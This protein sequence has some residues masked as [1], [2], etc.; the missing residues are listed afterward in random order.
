MPTNIFKTMPDCCFLVLT[1]CS[2]T[3]KLQLGIKN[4]TPIYIQSFHPKTKVLSAHSLFSA[5]WMQGIAIERENTV[6]LTTAYARIREKGAIQIIQQ[7][8]HMSWFFFWELQALSG[9]STHLS[10]TCEFIHSGFMC[11]TQNPSTKPPSISNSF[12]RSIT[13]TGAEKEKTIGFL[14]FVCSFLN[15]LS[16]S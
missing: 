5:W 13:C 1:W 16:Y 6:F 3:I 2:V 14:Q 11:S 9:L 12:S 8:Q 4:N 15:N 7:T 10:N